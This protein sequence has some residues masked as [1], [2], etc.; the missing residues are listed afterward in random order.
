MTSNLHRL[1]RLLQVL[2]LL[3]GQLDFEPTCKQTYQQ[4]ALHSEDAQI[5]AQN[6][7]QVIQARRANDGGGY[8]RLRQDPR[9]G[10]LR[11]ADALL[12]RKLFDPVKG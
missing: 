7:L 8:V 11:H 5:L 2:D 4:T 3:V 10:D 9:D 12:L 1:V 6:V